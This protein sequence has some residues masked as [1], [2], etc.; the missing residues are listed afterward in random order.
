MEELTRQ[1]NFHAMALS[2][3]VS[4]FS[5]TG[6]FSGPDG[7]TK[8]P[9]GEKACSSQNDLWIQLAKLPKI[10]EQVRSPWGYNGLLVA[11]KLETM[12]DEPELQA[13]AEKS[14]V[15][16][17]ADFMVANLLENA[18]DCAWLG[19]IKGNYQKMQRNQLPGALLDL[20]ESAK[21]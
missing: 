5:C 16:T 18:R 10:L 20:L 11:F 21:R 2:A 4:D 19:P 13:M 17:G 7:L 12:K 8:I 1:G 9:P 14:R 6:I 15:K 3:A